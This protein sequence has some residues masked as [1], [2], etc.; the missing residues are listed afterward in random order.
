MPLKLSMN[1]GSLSKT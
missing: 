1:V